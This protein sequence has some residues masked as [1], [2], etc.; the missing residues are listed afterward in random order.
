MILTAWPGLVLQDHD[1]P[2][3]RIVL[4]RINAALPVQSPYSISACYVP[5]QKKKKCLHFSFDLK[6][7]KISST[8]IAPISLS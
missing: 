5:W 3:N 1:Q 8:L 6:G 4:G 2:R 7:T